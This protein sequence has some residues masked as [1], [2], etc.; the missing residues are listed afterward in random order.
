[1]EDALAYM[2]QRTAFGGIIGRF[3]ILQHYVAD[4]A[5]WQKTTELLLYYVASLQAAGKPCGMEANMLK[6]VATENAVKAADLGIQILGGMGYSA[7]YQMQR[8]W[9]DVRLY[10]IGPITNQMVRNIV[11]ESV[12][13]PRSF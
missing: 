10:Q 8:Y 9:R 11:A 3:Q 7:E 2:K 1:M 12:G 6:M 4:I 13:L 5:T